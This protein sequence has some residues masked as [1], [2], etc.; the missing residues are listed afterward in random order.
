MLCDALFVGVRLHGR[1]CWCKSGGVEGIWCAS[2]AGGDLAAL[3]VWLAGCLNDWRG[4]KG[5]LGEILGARLHSAGSMLVAV[6]VCYCCCC[7]LAVYGGSVWTGG[8]G[9][10]AASGLGE[11]V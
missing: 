2:N 5:G 4:G 7:M 10:S 3:P 1:T 8:G 6:A 11:R 9:R